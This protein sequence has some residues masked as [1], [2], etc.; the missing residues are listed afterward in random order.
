MN[1]N[2]YYCC[3][4]SSACFFHALYIFNNCKLYL[5]MY[6]YLEITVYI[7][8]INVGYNIVIVL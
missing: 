7:V 6:Q 2:K 8:L 4:K 5:C 3:M 1:F